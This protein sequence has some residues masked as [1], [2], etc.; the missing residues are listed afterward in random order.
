[1]SSKSKLILDI[2]YADTRDNTAHDKHKHNVYQMIYVTEG[3]VSC[4]IAGRKTVCR[5]P[6]V[7]FIGNYE[8]H[9]ISPLSENYKRYVL[10]LD[11]YQTNTKLTPSLLS[12]VFSFHPDSFEHAIDVTPISEKIAVLMD[13]LLSEWHL[14]KE[15]K[16]PEGEALLLSS[17]LYVIRQHSPA[18]FSEKNFGA[19]EM[20]VSSVRMELECNFEGAL[21]LDALAD[22]YHISRYYLSHVFKQVTGYSLKEYLT[23]CRIS[24]ACQQ[25]TNKRPSLSIKEIAEASGFKDMS[26]FSRSFKQ[27]T[28]ITPTEF[29]KR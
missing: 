15:K 20:I 16:L 27:I 25:L 19:A 10:T 8:P 12:S 2:Y 26:N 21:D 1:M 9:I 7:V 24:F 29:R 17:L 23:L 6:A 11:P 28:G 14:P 13:N 22:R 18:H 5:A 3:T 4:E